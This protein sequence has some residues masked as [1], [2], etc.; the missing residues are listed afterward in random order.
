[1][2]GRGGVGVELLEGRARVGQYSLEPLDASELRV[3][4]A[5]S[6]VGCEL[7][8]VRKDPVAGLAEPPR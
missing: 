5:D 6:V 2:G 1:M 8:D 7:F 3:E 4:V